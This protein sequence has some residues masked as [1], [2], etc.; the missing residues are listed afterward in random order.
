[1]ERKLI[2][3][4]ILSSIF[5]TLSINSLYSHPVVSLPPYIVESQFG[6]IYGGDTFIVEGNKIY[7]NSSGL[8][9]RER[10]DFLNRSIWCP[11]SGEWRS[12]GYLYTECVSNE[13]NIVFLNLSL[14]YGIYEFKIYSDQPIMIGGGMVYENISSEPFHSGNNIFSIIASIDTA[15]FYNPP[16]GGIS[17]IIPPKDKWITCRIK[18]YRDLLNK[19]K[20]SAYTYIDGKWKTIIEDEKT[21]DKVGF[22]RF[23]ASGLGE[24]RFDELLIY[25]STSIKIYGVMEGAVIQL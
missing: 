19:S 20:Y 14:R 9:F 22:L 21:S 4:L 13:W 18:Y 5:L 17:N 16:P 25:R 2:L 7:R 15:F 23:M 8:I 1:M 24:A 12:V 6:E 11:V 3:L 10:F